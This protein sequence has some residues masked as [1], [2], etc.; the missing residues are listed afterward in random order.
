[1]CVCVIALV[2]LTGKV[3]YLVRLDV[4]AQISH[5]LQRLQ[6]EVGQAKLLK[7]SLGLQFRNQSAE[8]T[9]REEQMLEERIMEQE[10]SVQKERER[11]ARKESVLVGPRHHFSFPVSLQKNCST[12]I[13]FFNFKADF[14]ILALIDALVTPDVEYKQLRIQASG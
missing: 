4:S 2:L 3:Q 10:K 12:S 7:Q 9:E 14:S 11:T 8:S 1:M 13:L 5:L 6:I